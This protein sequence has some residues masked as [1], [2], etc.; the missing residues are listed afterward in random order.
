MCLLVM[1]IVRMIMRIM[2][3]Y[4]VC[5]N[6]RLHRLHHRQRRSL[7]KATSLIV[8]KYYHRNLVLSFVALSSTFLRWTRLSYTNCKGFYRSKEWLVN[9]GTL[10]SI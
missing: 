2:P 10:S 9:R 4:G 3:A 7:L 8:T 1:I 5:A 6:V